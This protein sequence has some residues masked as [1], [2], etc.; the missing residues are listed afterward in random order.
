MVGLTAGVWKAEAVVQGV[1]SLTIGIATVAMVTAIG[2]AV[3]WVPLIGPFLALLVAAA[4]AVFG[5]AALSGLLG[6]ILTPFVAGTQ[7]PVHTRPQVLQ[8]VPDQGPNDPAV[9]ISLDSV[10][11]E[12]QHNSPEDELVLLADISA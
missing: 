11:V 10:A 8:V 7:I 3:A 12:I 5:V 6:P 4:T 2:A 9:S 1:P